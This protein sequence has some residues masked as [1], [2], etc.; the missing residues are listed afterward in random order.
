MM[1]HRKGFS[2]AELVIAIV[3]ISICL[4]SVALMFQQALRADPAVKHLTVATALAQKTMEETLAAGFNVT[5]A[6]GTYADF[7]GYN[8]SI[9]QYYAV[10][11]TAL[12][13]ATQTPTEYKHIQVV[14]GYTTANGASNVTL[15][16]LVTNYTN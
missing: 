10:N 12:D 15:D 14:V 1:G 2:I 5:D 16:A 4:F 6:S 11:K 3:I 7:P 13:S 8:Y 9:S